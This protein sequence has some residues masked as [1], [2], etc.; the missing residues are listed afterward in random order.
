MK[1][2][3]TDPKDLR[4]GDKVGPFRVISVD[5]KPTTSHVFFYGLSWQDDA[6]VAELLKMHEVWHDD[7][8]PDIVIPA[9][10]VRARGVVGDFFGADSGLPGARAT[11]ITVMAHL[12]DEIIVVRGGIE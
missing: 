2:R 7:Q 4:A 11:D 3:V 10:K 12:G 5:P 1:I 8:E 9:D 6:V